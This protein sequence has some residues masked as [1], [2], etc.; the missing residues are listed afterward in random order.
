MRGPLTVVSCSACGTGFTDSPVT[1]AAFEEWYRTRAKHVAEESASA[2]SAGADGDDPVIDVQSSPEFSGPSP[3]FVTAAPP[4]SF[5]EML[6]SWMTPRG[7]LLDMGC[8]TG[9]FLAAL[10]RS[11]IRGVEGLDPSPLA[12]AAA[13]ALGIPVHIGTFSSL[14]GGMGRYDVVSLLGVLE[15][16][17]DVPEALAAIQSLLQPGGV[18]LLAVPDA[19]RYGDPLVV[20]FQDFNTEHTN[21]FSLRT[22]DALLGAHGFTRTWAQPA[23]SPFGPGLPPAPIM[24]GAWRWRA[25]GDDGPSDAAAPL[26]DADLV[27]ALQDFTRKSAQA[28]DALASRLDTVLGAA[29]DVTVWGAGELL[30]K[31]LATRAFSDRR[32]AAIVDGNPMGHGERLAGVEVTGPEAL[33]D[34]GTP[35]VVASMYAA[36][37]IQKEGARRGVAHRLVTLQSKP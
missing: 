15:H 10:K 30:Y 20:P 3:T 17:W 34:D 9:S 6:R 22:L 14:P 12:A 13:D 31:L 8:A 35:I 18:L 16:V 5:L 4:E 28:L 19:T 21:H 7:R 2:W 24:L 29:K 32:I 33:A 36:P 23:G 1:Q 26:L 37:A 25:P 11:G 27:D